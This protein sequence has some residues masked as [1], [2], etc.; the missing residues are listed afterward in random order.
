[1]PVTK[2]AASSMYGKLRRSA[3]R[4]RQRDGDDLGMA[5]VVGFAGSVLGEYVTRQLRRTAEEARPVPLQNE[6]PDPE[7]FV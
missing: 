7:L 2:V 1:M 3:E 6:G 5:L 4:A